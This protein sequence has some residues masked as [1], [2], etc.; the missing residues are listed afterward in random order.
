MLG[1]VEL[2]L[3]QLLKYSAVVGKSVLQILLCHTQYLF[4]PTKIEQDIMLRW[5]DLK[6][7]RGSA[8]LMLFARASCFCLNY[9]LWF[10][11]ELGWRMIKYAMWKKS[12]W[13]GIWE[14][15]DTRS[16]TGTLSKCLRHQSRKQSFVGGL[17][18][19]MEKLCYRLADS[20]EAA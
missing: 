3:Q 13:S 17:M 16:F 19:D 6:L 1:H 18:R 11:W 15:W 7:E 4:Q 9:S 10:S 14:E 2:S 12:V 20:K 5:G 8:K